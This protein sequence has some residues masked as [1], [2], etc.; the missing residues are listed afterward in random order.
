MDEVCCGMGVW[1]VGWVYMMLKNVFIIVIG[2]EYGGR[3]VVGS[4]K[5]LTLGCKV[6]YEIQ[7]K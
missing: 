2:R 1:L 7:P 3:R 5:M 6:R 4:W